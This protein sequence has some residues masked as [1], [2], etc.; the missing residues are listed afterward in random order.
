MFSHSSSSIKSLEPSM[1]E[2]SSNQTKPHLLQGD[3]TT[4]N[5]SGDGIPWE[6]TTET[7]TSL[8]GVEGL[9]PVGEKEAFQNATKPSSDALE[10]D[11]MLLC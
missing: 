3:V 6:E 2:A 10:V 4:V 9:G 5:L 8:P 1:E 11:Y 7:Q